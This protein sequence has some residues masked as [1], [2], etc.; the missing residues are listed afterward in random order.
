MKKKRNKKETEDRFLSFLKG[1]FEIIAV[2]LLLFTAFTLRLI[3]LSQIKEVNFL[4]AGGDMLTYHN[5]AVQ[6]LNGSFPKEPYYYN[7]LYPYFLSFV[8]SIF[9]PNP[10]IVKIVQAIMGV[11]LCL[12]VYLIARN[13]FDIK[14]ALI[15]LF[16]SIVYGLFILYEA[17]LLAE[18]LSTFLITVSLFFLLKPSWK[19][20]VFSGIFLGLSALTRANILLFIPFILIWMLIESNYPKIKTITIF[21]LLCAIV[22]LTI[23]PATIRNYSVSGKFILISTNGPINFWRGNNRYADGQ[24]YVPTLPFQH[25]HQQMLNEMISKKG[26]RA[27]LEDVMEFIKA[28][29]FKYFGLLGKKFLL[30]WEAT[31]IPNNISYEW[32]KSLSSVLRL[33]FIIDFGFIVP[34]G[35]LGAI[36]SWK[37]KK[38]LLL[39]L[40]LFAYSSATILF[41]VLSRYR[42]PVAPIFLVFCG[43]TISWWHECLKKKKIKPLIFS[44]ILFLVFVCLVNAR[45][46]I[47]LVYPHFFPNGAYTET[48]EGVL[49]KD[50]SD[51][52][53]EDKGLNL[54]NSKDKV[55]KKDLMINYSLDKFNQ[56]ELIVDASIIPRK[57]AK[58][59]VKINGN[60]FEVDISSGI[61]STEE[62]ITTRLSLPFSP[63]LLNEGKNIFEFKVTTDGYFSVPIDSSYRYGRSFFFEGKEWKEI[64][65][66]YQISLWLTKSHDKRT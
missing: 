54:L 48:D 19:R 64:N 21:C 23:S 26:D 18:T 30:F 63:K 62:L 44:L 32:V 31:E 29:P 9:G 5:Y 8:Y 20:I 53:K 50:I 4:L 10:Y 35:L 11:I 37:R 6:I 43:F 39:L 14:K 42:L 16:L 33:P 65:G 66:E 3:Y 13:V 52:P 46:G 15:S 1:H 41:L 55:L 24:Y 40:F 28:H 17:C 51:I 7:P 59:I 2:L 36:L 38:V 45:K 27:Y 56:A 49:I 22:F 61:H 47:C 25:V 57:E 34:L 12:L 58:L 60:L